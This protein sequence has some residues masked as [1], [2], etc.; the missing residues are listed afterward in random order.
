MLLLDPVPCQAR[1]RTTRRQCELPLHTSLSTSSAIQQ[2][3]H[4]NTSTLARD[5]TALQT[6]MKS[7]FLVNTYTLQCVEAVQNAFQIKCSVY[8]CW[9]IRAVARI[10]FQPR[11]RGKPGIWGRSPSGV[12]RQGPWSGRKGARPLKLKAL[13]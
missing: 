9:S 13:Q 2:I 5:Y 8:V 6:I 1:Q 12:Q 7:N 11:Q 10:L 3:K 4:I